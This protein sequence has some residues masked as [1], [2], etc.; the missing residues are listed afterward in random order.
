MSERSISDILIDDG[1]RGVVRDMPREKYFGLARL[2]ASTIKPGLIG[3]AEVDPTAIRAAFEETRTP[4]S[5]T[6]QDSFDKGSLTHVL[7]FEPETIVDKVA[8]WKGSRRAGR[9]WDEFEVANV[10]KLIMREP[11]VREVQRAVRELRRVPQVASLLNRKHETELPVLGQ[12]GRTYCKG[13]LDAITTDGPATLIDLKTTS[14]GID[15]A[16]VLR[17]IR[18]LHYREQLSFY[19]DL[20]CQATGILVDSIVLLFVSLD[21]IGVRIVKLTTS[22]RQFGSSRMMAAIEAVERCIAADDWPVFCGDSICDV[23]PWEVDDLDIE[24]L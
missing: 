18:T 14:H 1:L 7:I 8:V 13:L 6:L 11:D 23:N 2:N 9:E 3:S 5:A 12:F 17:T 16:S 10:G 20:Y 24:G 22:A 15:E 21:P 19:A 4:P